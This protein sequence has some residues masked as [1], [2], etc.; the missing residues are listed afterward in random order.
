M[1]PSVSRTPTPPAFDAVAVGANVFV[2]IVL[3]ERGPHG[4]G[5]GLPVVGWFS[6]GALPAVAETETETE[7]N[8]SGN[9]VRRARNSC[10][11]FCGGWKA[12]VHC[13]GAGVRRG[14]LVGFGMVFG[15][16]LGLVLV[17]MV[18][19]F[20]LRLYFVWFCFIKL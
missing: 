17:G 16:V 14:A 13:G 12:S 8:A 6:V 4:V 20:R 5:A 19:W 7:T 10:G 18:L 1:T 9:F 11:R 3:V 2:A 15:V